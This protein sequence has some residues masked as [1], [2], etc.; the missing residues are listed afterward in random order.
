MADPIT[1]ELDDKG[2][3]G[4]LPDPLQR[5][6]DRKVSEA[7]SKAEKNLEEKLKAA[8]V[9]PAEKERL[10]QL[11]EEN[12]RFKEDQARK[13]KD[14]ETADKIKEERHAA[15]LKEREEKLT[16][17]DREIVRRDE[18]LRGM[19][20]TEIRAAAVAAGAR[21]ESL[22]ELE[23]LLGAQLDLDGES[24]EPFVK[25][26]DGK[27]LE[28]DGKRVSIEAHVKQYL[29]DHAHHI[30]ATRSRSGRAPGGATMSGASHTVG[31]DKDQAIAAA[32]ENPSMSNVTTAVGAVRRRAS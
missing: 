25:G 13:A 14:Y 15:A 17:K 12:S 4:A 8:Q 28:K 32:E 23:T 22:A 30:N 27:P 10:K 18:R 2:N 6:F 24:L 16:A 11:E 3:L 5:A 29:A 19:L 1:V 20:K 7:V 9:D 31:S 21:T 26:A